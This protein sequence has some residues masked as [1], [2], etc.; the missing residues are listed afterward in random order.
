MRRQRVQLGGQRSL[1]HQ[2]HHRWR[3]L[4]FTLLVLVVVSILVT[5]LVL[6]YTWYASQ[7]Q[8]ALP[9][10]ERPA[11][12]RSPD[13]KPPLTPD[14]NT[15]I[16][17]VQQAL[18]SPVAKGS[19]VALSIKTLPGAACSIKFT[20]NNNDIE[21]RD[22]GLIPKIADEFGMAEWAWTVTADAQTG[23]WPAE[24]T[25]A[26]HDKSAYL[27]ADIQVQ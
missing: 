9:E 20:Y 5:G 16:S 27:R 25:C 1:H 2:R 10:P 21:S 8:P 23:V 12:A 26:L 13:V 22:S 17:I 11:P 7:Q 19:N 24:V 6:V 18:S 15:P 14:E 4:R 3:W